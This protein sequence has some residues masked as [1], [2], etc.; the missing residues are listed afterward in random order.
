MSLTQFDKSNMF[1]VE[2]NVDKSWVVVG[3]YTGLDFF[4]RNQELIN[5]QNVSQFALESASTQS[6]FI[7]LQNALFQATAVK[8]VKSPL[9][10]ELD[11]L[12]TQWDSLTG[13]FPTT[14]IKNHDSEGYLGQIDPP[15]QMEDP[16]C[17]EQSILGCVGYVEPSVSHTA[18]IV[19]VV[20]AVVVAIAIFI[21]LLCVLL[22]CKKNQRGFWKSEE[23]KERDEM[24]SYIPTKTHTFTG[25]TAAPTSTMGTSAY[26]PTAV[27]MSNAGSATSTGI[28]S[29]V[30]AA[31]NHVEVKDAALP[32]EYKAYKDTKGQIFYVNTETM[33][34]SWNHP[35]KANEDAEGG[36]SL[37]W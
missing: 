16:A 30:Q 1:I 19:G 36:H 21:T 32:P 35:T 14:P 4:K 3:M 5:S 18:L 10:F 31:N 37:G 8:E 15:N 33:Q 13:T 25:S 20:V 6:R 29:S 9:P 11:S 17:L 26:M 34:T 24:S 27:E 2:H 12:Y 22:W 7:S 23:E 28:G